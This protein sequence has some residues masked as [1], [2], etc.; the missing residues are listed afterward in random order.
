MRLVITNMYGD[1]ATGPG[2]HT[3]HTCWLCFAAE[4][5]L[6][7]ISLP[8]ARL[9]RQSMSEAPYAPLLPRRERSMAGE[10]PA[11]GAG[12]ASRRTGADCPIEHHR[13]RPPG[14]R[15]WG[16]HEAAVSTDTGADCPDP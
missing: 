6:P 15:A 16:A 13:R 2:P 14:P 12:A 3:T 9:P 7:R 1:R 11:R 8:A 10:A 5:Q 4:R